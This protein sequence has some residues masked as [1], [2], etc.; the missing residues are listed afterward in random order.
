MSRGGTRFIVRREQGRS[1]PRPWASLRQVPN[2]G[3]PD[4]L[5]SGRRRRQE[6]APAIRPEGSPHR[7]PFGVVFQ[8]KQDG[9]AIS[10]TAA[11]G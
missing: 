6:A 7:R 4:N 3:S 2:Q 8:N 10:A 5:L 11:G 1:F 9:E